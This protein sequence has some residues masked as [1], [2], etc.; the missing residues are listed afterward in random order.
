MSVKILHADV[1]DGLRSLP[2]DSVHCVVTS[3]PYWKVRDYGFDG[4]LGLEDTM[5]EHIENMV[6][7]FRL[8]WR[9]LRDDGVLWLNY[10]DSY[11]TNFHGPDGHNFGK[12]RAYPEDLQAITKERLRTIPRLGK[13][14]ITEVREYL[15]ASG[16]WVPN[17]PAA[18]ADSTTVKP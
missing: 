4:Q 13:R 3:P 6:S 10:G 2:S 11:N 17:K 15:E 8:V 16:I 7:V 9:V 18:R 1:F 14:G 12:D 5:E